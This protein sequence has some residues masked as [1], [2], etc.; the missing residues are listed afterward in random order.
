MFSRRVVEYHVEHHADAVVGERAHEFIEVIHGADGGIDVV[1]VGNIIAAVTLWGDEKWIEPNHV[2]PEG[3]YVGDFFDDT[4]K[5]PYATSGRI[6][7]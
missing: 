2:D 3:G 7:K 6:L 4:P 1:V 5:V